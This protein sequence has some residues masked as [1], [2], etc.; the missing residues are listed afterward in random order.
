[1]CGE[2]D[3]DLHTAQ[4]LPMEPRLYRID[5][6][7]PVCWEDPFTIRVGFDRV[8]ARV[9]DPS[10]GVQRLISA[11]RTGVHASRIRQMSSQLGVSVA[12]EAELLK[13]LRNVF[14]RDRNEQSSEPG[15]A[16]VAS[17]GRRLAVRVSDGGRPVT[18]LQS[19]I[20][21]SDLFVLNHH[22][23]KSRVCDLVVLVERYFEPLSAGQ[24][25]LSRGVPHLLIRFTDEHATIGPIIAEGGAPCLSCIALHSV[26]A[27]PALPTLSAQL[28]GQPAAAETG[29][30]SELA[31]VTALTMIRL[32]MRGDVTMHNTRVRFTVRGG[33]VSTVPRIEQVG[34]H[35]KCACTI[36][37]K[38][39]PSG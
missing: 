32:W 29:A 12:E 17:K 18:A 19:A 36:L 7:L 27:D 9:V 25:W 1:M 14:L 34:P 22:H 3:R 11:L 2:L 38:L 5:P 28:V 37:E 21:T 20:A 35:P 30:S 24:R 6:Q 33:L 15:D 13:A 10:A 16:A 26:T 23:E 4:T 31:A 8:L 39:R